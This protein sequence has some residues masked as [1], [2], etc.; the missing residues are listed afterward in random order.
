LQILTLADHFL[1]CKKAAR[2]VLTKELNFFKKGIDK[3]KR[4]CYNS[5]AFGEKP[6]CRANNMAG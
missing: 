3:E 4:L 6:L 5:R 2:K 1:W